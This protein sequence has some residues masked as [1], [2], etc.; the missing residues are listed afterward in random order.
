MKRREF[1]A[2]LGAAAWPFAARA[3]QPA[4][5]V[6]GLLYLG[7]PEGSANLLAAFRKGLNETGFVE[8][9][10]LTIEYRW[11]QNDVARLPDLVVDLV[12]RRVAVIATLGSLPGAL[13]A[14]AATATIPI[15]F[16]TGADPVQA[17]LVASLNRPG[18]NVTGI[19]S[20]NVA[21]GAK[22][23]GLLHELLPGAVRFAVLVN[24]NS[25]NVEVVR[26]DAQAAATAIGRQIEVLTASSNREIDTAFASVAQ[27]RADA[28]VVAPSPLFDNRRVQLITLA[29][30]HRVPTIY[31]QRECPEAGGLMSYGSS[32]TDEFRHV[33]VYTGRV[34]KGEKPADLPVMQPTTFEFVINL[35][36]A[37]TLG[38]EVPPAWLAI[39]DEV[40]E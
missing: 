13:A 40:I 39:A 2:G 37:R 31:S 6:I 7:S 16:S 23:L 27:M 1:I 24:S 15:V 14:K 8:G 9:R 10:N 29:A 33:G 38:I 4:V 21:L 12:R 30:H 32:I 36:T 26:R 22:R 34:L 35:Q 25:P 20:M 19:V 17:G 11:G 3:Q 28:L 5:S 18:G